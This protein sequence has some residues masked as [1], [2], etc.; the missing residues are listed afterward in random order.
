MIWKHMTTL[1]WRPIDAELTHAEKSFMH[2]H[3]SVLKALHIFLS[4]LHWRFGTA[5]VLKDGF[6]IGIHLE[7]ITVLREQIERKTIIKDRLTDVEGC[8]DNFVRSRQAQGCSALL[9]HEFK[10]VVSE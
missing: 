8:L 10:N 7:T 1:Y 5:L 2:H 4:N 3:L 6:L 9:V